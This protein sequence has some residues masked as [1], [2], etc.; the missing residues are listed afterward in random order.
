[1]FVSPRAYNLYGHAITSSIAYPLIAWGLVACFAIHAFTGIALYAQNKAA[2]GGQGYAVV[3]SRE[4][5]IRLATK[6]ILASGSLILVFLVTHLA[7]FKYGAHYT[8]VYDGLEVRDLFKLMVEKFSHPGFVAWY[9]VA[10]A[11]LGFHLRHGFSSAF[12]SLGINHPNYTPL[13]K[14]A[15]VLYAVLVAVGFMTQPLYILFFYKG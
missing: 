1:M 6:M 14:Q 11:L 15:G 4:K 9:L 12:Q 10:L 8:V 3:A 5:D 13:I 2:R 7:S